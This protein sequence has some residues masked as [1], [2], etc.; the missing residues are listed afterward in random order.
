MKYSLN[1]LSI[2]G[3]YYLL[4]PKLNK[5]QLRLIQNRLENKDFKGRQTHELRYSLAKKFIVVR[6]SGVLYSNFEALDLVGPLIPSILSCEREALSIQQAC[7]K[8]FAVLLDKGRKVIRFKPRIEAFTLWTELRK[9]D[10]SGLTPDEAYILANML[11]K[12]RGKILVLTDFPTEDCHIKRIGKRQYYLC[13]I[14][15]SEF[16]SNLRT[17]TEKK[18][19]NCYLPRNSIIELDQLEEPSESELV[20]L[21]SRLGEWFSFKVIAA[22]K[23]NSLRF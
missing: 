3:K 17:I 18:K 8:Y 11:S 4:L 12:A 20:D 16:I 10:Q 15:V 5:M 7:D 21:I 9:H 23:P 14:E 1:Q 2:L 19:R 6:E 22:K 13:N